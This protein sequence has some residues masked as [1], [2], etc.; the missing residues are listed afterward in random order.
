MG[1]SNG[2]QIDFTIPSVI[3][4]NV[5]MDYPEILDLVELPILPIE[6]VEELDALKN[7]WDSRAWKAREALRRIKKI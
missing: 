4:T 7:R 5:L 6:V 2:L 3:D 1:N